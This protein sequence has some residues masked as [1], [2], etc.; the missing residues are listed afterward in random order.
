MK[1]L[2]SEGEDYDATSATSTS[3]SENVGD[4]FAAEKEC[5]AMQ[6]RYPRRRKQRSASWGRSTPFRALIHI[7][8]L[9][10]IASRELNSDN[11]LCFFFLL[12]LREEYEG[13]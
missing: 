10:M 6:A 5:R 11:T 12:R 2:D 4:T 8:F 3:C 13:D 1:Y 9:I 7:L